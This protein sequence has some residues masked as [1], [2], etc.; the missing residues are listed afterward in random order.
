M[1]FT[2]P[3]FVNQF[4][5]ATARSPLLNRALQWPDPNVPPLDRE[6]LTCAD[7]RL[8]VRIDFALTQTVDLQADEPAGMCLVDRLIDDIFDGLGVDPGLNPRPPGN[9]AYLF[10]PSLTKNGWPS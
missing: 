3:M 10:H 6:R 5:G 1:N 2:T 7:S 4:R 8:G 9:D